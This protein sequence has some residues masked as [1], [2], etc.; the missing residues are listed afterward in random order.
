MTIH[1]NAADFP[2][3]EVKNA[4][5]DAEVKTALAALT[6]AAEK[7]AKSTQERLD[8]IEAKVNRAAMGGDGE[9]DPA[10]VKAA[11]AEFNQFMRKGV[12]PAEGKAMSVGSDPDGGYMVPDVL[13]STMTRR[14][15]DL[16]PIRQY[17]RVVT[18]S[19][20]HFEEVADNDEADAGWAT[21]TVTNGETGTPQVAKFRVPVHYL[22]AEPKT[23]Q[24]V[25]DD[26]AFNV[27]T[28]LGSKVSNKFART[29][30]AAFIS[31]NGAGKPRGFLTLT[32]GTAD[33]DTRT[34]GQIQYVATGTDGALGTGAAH[35]ADKLIDLQA[36][37]KADYRPGAIWLMNRRT[38][39]AY[40]KVKTSQGDFVW[41]DSLQAGQP[42]QLLGHP[43]VL[44]ED[45]PSFTGT[46]E[47]PVA[48]A[49]LGEGYTVVDR[50]GVT[51]LRDPFT[52][53]GFVKF[54]TRK[55]VG[56]DVNNSEAIKLLKTSTN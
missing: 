10:E 46:G 32:T 18:I 30:A 34:W 21:E 53:K 36:T 22:E 19:N 3:I 13:A 11:R 42:P 1:K 33:D 28:W 29:E 23:T 7:A 4:P 48:F 44:A 35:A 52:S 31:G 37:M 51:V 5:E 26:S 55:R 40:R 8:Q 43:V 47:Y 17:A 2:R 15:F 12:Q 45:M 41:Q 49:N 20:D 56:G 14:A 24:Q 9:T 6:D 39:A 16:S 25:L 27:E 38:A 54:F 50:Q